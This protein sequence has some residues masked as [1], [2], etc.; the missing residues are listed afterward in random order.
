MNNVW[1]TGSLPPAWKSA[2]IT[3]VPKP[4]KDLK[5]ENL[6]PI[7]LTSCL[8]KLLEHV[9]L[10]RLNRHMEAHQLFPHTMVGFRPSLSTQD[11]M[12]QLQHQIIDNPGVSPL[13]TR[14]IMGLDLTKA[15][16]CV[17]HSAIL[18]N[19]SDL[20]VGSKVYNY[21]ADFLSQRT[22]RLTVQGLKSDPI[23]LGSRGTPQGSVLSPFLFNVA[24]IKLP[25]L[26]QQ[27]TD[28]HHSL[29]ADDIT[30]WTAGGSDGD[31]Q[32]R[33]QEAATIVEN[34]VSTRGLACSPQKS[35]LLFFRPST[36]GRHRG[37]TRIYRFNYR[38]ASYLEQR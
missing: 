1:D 23:L 12:L 21:I 29:Y 15:F 8:G 38:G 17:A 31:I 30:I 2:L 3:L 6:R 33:L 10:N 5:L 11:V 35:E 19:L 22:T 9:V 36:A 32:E 4:G 34:Y 27:I 20:N 37:M 7:S 13:D 24:M 16:D 28:V 25:P 26:L 18:H 14:V